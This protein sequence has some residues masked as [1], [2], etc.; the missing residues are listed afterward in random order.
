[1]DYSIRDAQLIS[2]IIIKIF[3]TSLQK[4]IKLCLSLLSRPIPAEMP[5]QRG[6]TRYSQDFISCVILVNQPEF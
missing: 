1:M 3:S 2:L 6:L 5:A 4:K